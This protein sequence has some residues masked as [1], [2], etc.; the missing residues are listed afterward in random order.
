MVRLI[1]DHS[2]RS[3]HAWLRSQTQPNQRTG[4]DDS[5]YEPPGTLPRATADVRCHTT[6]ADGVL[7]WAVL[8]AGAANAGIFRPRE[9]KELPADTA[10]RP[11]LVVRPGEIVVSRANTRE[12]VGSAAVVE[13]HFPRLMLSDKLYAIGLDPDLAVPEYVA[14][15]LRTRRWRGLIEINATG[16]SPS[17]QNITREEI[18]DLPIP[19]PPVDEQRKV[20]DD[21]ARQRGEVEQLVSLV[22]RQQDLLRE[23]RQALI[24]AA[25]TGEIEV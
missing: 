19:S 13:G 23:R 12:L 9:N 11:D 24:T 8:K 1:D 22:R 5:P 20:V 14:A 3:P 6:S 7:T 17:M 15:V 16:A 10:P 25:V 21:L 18:L 2:V 4:L